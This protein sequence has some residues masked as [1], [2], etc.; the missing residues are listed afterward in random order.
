MAPPGRR[1]DLIRANVERRGRGSRRTGPW[2]T[3]TL[4]FQQQPPYLYRVHF[5][6]VPVLYSKRVL[7]SLG[8]GLHSCPALGPPGSSTQAL[9]VIGG[10]RGC[11]LTGAGAICTPVP[12]GTPAPPV[13]GPSHSRRVCRCPAWLASTLRS[14]TSLVRDGGPRPTCWASPRGGLPL[15]R[16]LQWMLG[17]SSSGN[18]TWDPLLAPF[19][20]WGAAVAP[21]LAGR[22]LSGDVVEPCL[23]LVPPQ[24]GD[25][26]RAH[27]WGVGPRMPVNNIL[28]HFFFF[29]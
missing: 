21:A 8:L 17:M 4:G 13:L 22:M 20:G 16:T 11:C 18:P 27:A 15:G 25:R 2:L 26:D 3:K 6:L 5:P 10:G 28:V 9:G 12:L 14:F 23:P 24:P 1:G 7:V 29:F 19:Q